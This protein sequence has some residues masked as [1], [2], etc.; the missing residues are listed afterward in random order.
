MNEERKD[1]AYWLFVISAF[2]AV[3]CGGII[4][5]YSLCGM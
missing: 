5:G 2:V 1:I 4:L 3:F